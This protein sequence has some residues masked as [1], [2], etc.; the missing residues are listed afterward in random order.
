MAQNPKT[1]SFRKEKRLENEVPGLQTAPRERQETARSAPGAPSVPPGAS[2]SRQERPGSASGGARSA[3]RGPRGAPGRLHL[4]PPGASGGPPGPPGAPRGP[5][6]A[7]R[8]RQKQ[9]N[10]VKTHKNTV[11]Y[12]VLP[13]KITFSLG[14]A[15][16][17]GVKSVAKPSE[18]IILR[19]KTL[20]FTRFFFIEFQ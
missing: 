12:T 3:P 6:G 7:P 9:E 18:N 5:P 13:R 11:K 17:W 8:G 15:V 20:Y 14:L 10:R 19:A 1:K 16:F 2:K 4:G